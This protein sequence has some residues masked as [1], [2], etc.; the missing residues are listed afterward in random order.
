MAFPSSLGVPASNGR[1]VLGER[2]TSGPRAPAK[3][4]APALAG[5]LSRRP[6]IDAME[7]TL[8]RWL[9]YRDEVAETCGLTQEQLAKT[10]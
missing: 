7:E 1:P 5:R 6:V 9:T 8:R 4:C 3:G 2:G 10:G